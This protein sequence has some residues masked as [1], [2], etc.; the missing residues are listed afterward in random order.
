MI[1][2][3]SKEAPPFPDP[4][5][6]STAFPP[7]TPSRKFTSF[8]FP[9]FCFTFGFVQQQP[10]LSQFLLRSQSAKKLHKKTGPGQDQKCQRFCHQASSTDTARRALQMESIW[11]WLMRNIWMKEARTNRNHQVSH[12]HR[13][14]W[15]P[16][17]FYLYVL[18]FV[19]QGRHMLLPENLSRPCKWTLTSGIP[20]SLRSLP[21]FCAPVC[22]V[23]IVLIGYV[24]MEDRWEI[25]FVTVLCFIFPGIWKGQ[26]ASSLN[27]LTAPK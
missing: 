14:Q 9:V 24:L 16:Q 1:Q 5:P 4:S 10:P 6:S 17:N 18:I 11:M 2:S 20:L 25:D 3:H 13:L 8:S 7:P 12:C 15:L 23:V 22:P 21:H 19:T 26:K 27:V